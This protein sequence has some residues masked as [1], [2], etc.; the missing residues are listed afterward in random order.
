[1]CNQQEA[2]EKIPVLLS[3]RAAKRFVSIEPILGSVQ[4]MDYLQPTGEN[5]ANDHDDMV[6]SRGLDWVIAGAET[7]QNARL[8]ELD[9]FA[10]LRDQCVAAKVPFFLKQVNARGEDL[11][12]SEKIKDFPKNKT[13]TS[14][15]SPHKT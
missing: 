8:A 6:S 15:C 5:A 2:D 11:L 10:S 3:I 13:V 4:I 14:D 1:M 12:D 9:W 7:G